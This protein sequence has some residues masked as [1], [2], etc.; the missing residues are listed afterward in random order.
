MLTIIKL[1]ITKKTIIIK[2]LNSRAPVISPWRSLDIALVI[3]HDI[4]QFAKIPVL[5][6]R[7]PNIDG[8]KCLFMLTK[9]EYFSPEVGTKI[10][11][12]NI[13]TRLKTI[14]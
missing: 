4:Q 13:K 6:Q 7:L 11:I 12:N 3:P 10:R 9:G 14:A 8:S 5:G 2:L 1:K